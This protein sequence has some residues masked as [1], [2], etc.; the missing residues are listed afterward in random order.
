MKTALAA[1]TFAAILLLIACGEDD[2][3]YTID[4][5]RPDRAPL[6]PSGERLTDLQRLGLGRVTG[7]NPHGGA[8]PHGGA[9]PQR[10]QAP[11]FAFDLPDGWKKLPPKQ[12]RDANF[13]LERDPSVEC[14][15]TVMPGGGGGLVG[16]VSRWY[17]QMKQ[18]APQAGAITKLPK[19]EMFKREATLVE[20]TGTFIGRGGAP[21]ENYG[22]L[23]AYLELPGTTLTLKMTGPAEV[24]SA[25]RD[26][27]VRVAA[28]LRLDAAHGG[29]HG[30][31]GM[32]PQPKQP[33]GN[34]GIASGMASG[35]SGFAWDTPKGWTSAVLHRH[36][37]R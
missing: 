4:E 19:I 37:G 1:S 14:F 7:A 28:S 18:P 34:D 10:P 13:T 30:G 22:F 35:A 9:N 16:N 24:V 20:L 31:S 17:G 12:F 33:A 26:N 15:L 25:E 36:D 21:K 8:D 5:V 3:N 27:F 29:P 6:I 11:T 32:G 2:R 23:A